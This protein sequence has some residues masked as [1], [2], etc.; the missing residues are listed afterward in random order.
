MRYGH[1][2]LVFALFVELAGCQSREK[3]ITAKAQSDKVVAVSAD[4]PAMLQAF[5]RAR[6]TLDNFLARV[7]ETTRWS[8]SRL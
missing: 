4:D 1:P 7:A 6:G 5:S 3:N 2:F 8:S